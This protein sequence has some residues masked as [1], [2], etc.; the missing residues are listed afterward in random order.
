MVKKE[1]T[2][3]M[4][5]HVAENM[6]ERVYATITLLAVIAVHW[7]HADSYSIKAVEFG[8]IGTVVALWLATLVSVR[9]AYRAVHG[10]SIQLRDYRHLIF[11]SSGL[12]APAIIPM[13]LVLASG[14]GIYSM[15]TGLMASMIVLLLELFV[16][17]FVAG[18][19]IYDSLPRLII[20]SCAEM[21]VGIGVILLKIAV[22][23]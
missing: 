20:V 16:L 15:K 6:K 8:I 11:T 3:V 19:K 21:S 17:S 1:S 14:T 4:R 22:G 7:Q 12:L 18:R 23:E 10:R 2:P 5:E 13:I 9:M